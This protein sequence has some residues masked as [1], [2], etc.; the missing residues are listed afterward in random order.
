MYSLVVWH[1]KWSYSATAESLLTQRSGLFRW[2][3]V[4]IPE[5][6]AD[7]PSFSLISIGRFLF[8]ALVQ[9]FN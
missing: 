4:A 2:D 7:L 3:L 1:C 5:I 8:L 9:S 6:G